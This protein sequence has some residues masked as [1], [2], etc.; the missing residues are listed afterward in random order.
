MT[1]FTKKSAI[2]VVLSLAVLVV[3]VIPIAGSRIIETV[4]RDRSSATEEEVLDDTMICDCPNI[5]DP[6]C[7]SDGITYD[8]TCS[9]ECLGVTVEYNG[10]CRIYD[11]T[12]PPPECSS[13]T[14]ICGQDEVFFE[15]A[16]ECPICECRNRGAEPGV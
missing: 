7:G 6:V 13:C 8:H 10:T 11:E 14:T 3:L 2:P 4:T 1:F 9:A 16:K 12:T 5:S 15:D